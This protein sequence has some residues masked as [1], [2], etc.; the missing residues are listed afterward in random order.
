MK[1]VIA[2]L[3]LLVSFATAY[4]GELCF[5]GDASGTCELTSWCADHHGSD[6]IVGLCPKDPNDVRCCFYPDCVGHSG[7]CDI[8]GDL[9]CVGSYVAGYCPG[10]DDYECC[11][12][13]ED[14]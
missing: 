4:I 3:S 1:F 2:L 9:G 13:C 12:S 7:K 11:T 5:N 6:S 8:L 10:P 14:C